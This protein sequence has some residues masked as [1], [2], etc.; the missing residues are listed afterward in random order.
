MPGSLIDGRYRIVKMVGE[1]GM[2]RVYEAEDVR[3]HERVALKVLL[4]KLMDA[5]G[6]ITRFQREVEILSRIKN[7]A[8]PKVK[9]WG[10]FERE[11]YYV[12]EFISGINLSDRLKR[13][14]AWDAVSA[15]RLVARVADALHVAHR[16]GV[17]HRDV[18]PH[19][20]MLSNSGSVHL[21]D[22]GVAR[23]PVGDMKTITTTG[24][25]VGT[26]EYMAPEQLDSHRVDRRCD[27]YSLGVVLFE[28]LTGS[29]PFSGNTPFEVALKHKN[30]PPPQPRSL[31]SDIPLW[32]DKI[33]MKCL[34]KN[35]ENRY[36]S[37]AELRDLLNEERATGVKRRRHLENGD[38][39]IENEGGRNRW[40]LVMMSR[41]EK[42]S[43]EPGI[44]L[45]FEGHF[46]HLD[47]IL[48]PGGK[49]KDWT[50][51]FSPLDETAILRRVIDYRA[52]CEYQFG[53][54]WKFR[55]V[56]RRWFG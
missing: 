7:S 42:Y 23:G 22:F 1:G 45:R 56:L 12:S 5:P 32:L 53:Q 35:P 49:N 36:S 16:E 24:M 25:I 31:R 38:L 13:D 47:E 46:F 39:V 10:S 3:D 30:D 8:V 44:S 28:L 15:C 50:Y 33:V 41:V 48:S 51:R 21:V 55:N 34:E 20:I 54:R 17:I 27:I 40:P 18:K 6:A 19:N 37:A 43:W 14:G 52:D 2:G 26:P 11:H 29:R 9:A 4:K